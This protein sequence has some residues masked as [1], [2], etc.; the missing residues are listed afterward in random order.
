VQQKFHQRLFHLATGRL[1]ARSA[2]VLVSL[3]S[4]LDGILKAWLLIALLA[5]SARAVA[6]PAGIE[7]TG[8]PSVIAYFLLILAPVVSTLLALR[9]F[10]DADRQPSL[11][12]RLALVGRWRD[13]SSREARSHPLYGANGIMVSLLVGMLMNVPVRAAEF[14]AAMPPMPSTAPQW[15]SVLQAAM[16]FDVVLFTSLYPIAFV[17]AL[18][19]S[20]IFPRLLV[21]IWMLDIVMQIG[22]A[23]V[24]AQSTQLPPAVADALQAL[25]TGNV[26]KVLISV[27]W[28]LPYL[29]LSTRVNVT[30]RQRVPA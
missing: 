8:A 6:A 24:V 1:R 4:G 12:T 7:N 13:V 22:I 26:K 9:W 23:R 19:R 25:L 28:W 5:C 11:S 10:E 14:L 17:A 29:L 15:A 20:P 18:K 27:A 21:A 16:T 30:Y 3:E 2:A